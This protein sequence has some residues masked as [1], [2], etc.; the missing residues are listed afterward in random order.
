MTYSY[1]LPCIYTLLDNVVKESR[2]MKKRIPKNSNWQ[3]FKN[4]GIIRINS[5]NAYCRNYQVLTK[6]LGSVEANAQHML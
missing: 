6:H 3:H 4:F 2:D 1:V 5:Y